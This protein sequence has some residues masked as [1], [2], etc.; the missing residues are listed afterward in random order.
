[1][2]QPRHAGRIEIPL[3]LV[4]SFATILPSFTPPR[5]RP[6]AGLIQRLCRQFD[7]AR[8]NFSSYHLTLKRISA[9]GEK[10]H[11]GRH[12]AKGGRDAAVRRHPGDRRDACTGG[13][14]APNQ[15]AV[16]APTSS[17]STIERSGPEPLLGHDKEL[18]RR[19]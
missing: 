10:W 13:P 11:A 9:G 12:N 2:A 3:R 16:L 7:G 1:M 18:N 14:F 19:Q 6:R 15:L 17:R 4:Q 8:M 5:R